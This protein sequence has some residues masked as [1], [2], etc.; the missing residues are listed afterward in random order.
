MTVENRRALALMPHP[1]DAEIQ[2][3]GTLI[4]LRSLGWEIYIATMTAGDKGSAT[5]TCEEI[6]ALRR[7]EARHGAQAIGAASYTCLEF[8]DLEITFDSPSRHRVAHML[9]AVDPAIVFTTPPWDYMPDHVITSQ[10][11]RDACF[12]AAVKNYA[13]AEGDR[14]TAGLPYLYY[15]D[16]LGGCDLFG[17]PVR[18]NCIVDISDQMRQKTDALA[19]HVSQR[20]WLRRQHG[21]DEYIEAMQRSGAM[22]GRSIEAAYGE[23]FCQHRGHPFPDDNVLEPLLGAVAIVQ[24]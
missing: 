21:M 14:P 15:T 24:S 8:D 20:E 17:D 12:N 6:G 11:V 16:A 22:R 9:R 1:D 4:R 23:A 2:C 3:A 18:I 19:C 7:E 13:T 5:L 10:L